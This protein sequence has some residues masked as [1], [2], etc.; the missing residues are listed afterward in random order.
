MVSLPEMYNN[1][2]NKSLDQGFCHSAHYHGTPIPNPIPAREIQHTPCAVQCTCAVLLY[3][4][5]YTVSSVFRSSPLP[6]SKGAGTLRY[7][8]SL[9]LVY[10]RM[11]L[12]L[13]K[14]EIFWSSVGFKIGAMTRF[15]FGR[16]FFANREIRDT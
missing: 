12:K 13:A 15:F 5:L 16:N 4:T 14:K 2:N 11:K 8:R 6:L 3:I 9:L 10:V 1:N 7:L